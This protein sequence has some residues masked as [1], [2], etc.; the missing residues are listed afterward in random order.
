[1]PCV[2]PLGTGHWQPAS[3][4]AAIH[5]SE[6]Q[7][8][9]TGPPGCEFNLSKAREGKDQCSRGAMSPGL[10]E[11]SVPPE[12]KRAQGMPG[13]GRNPWPPCNKE[14]TGKEPQVQPDHPAF[15]AQWVYGLYVLS[16]V[17]GLVCHRRRTMRLARL[18]LSVGRPGPY[19]FPVRSS[20]VRPH[21]TSCASLPGPSHPASRF[22]TIAHTPLKSEAGRAHHTP[23]LHSDK[24]NILT[25]TA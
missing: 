5:D 6:P 22:V 14:S 21:E 4:R 1:M 10:C 20:A 17:T 8:P 13:A 9:R 19:D 11:K 12:S 24:Q 23:I 25:A 15:P 16:P 3:A 7:V 18:G 2:L